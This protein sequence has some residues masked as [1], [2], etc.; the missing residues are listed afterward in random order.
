RSAVA[1]ATP[2]TPVQAA[3]PPPPRLSSPVPPTGP[4]RQGPRSKA[5][6]DPV[7]PATSQHRPVRAGKA[8][9]RCSQHDAASSATARRVTVALRPGAMGAAVP[10]GPALPLAV[11]YWEGDDQHV[12]HRRAVLRPAGPCD[13]APAPLPEGLLRRDGPWQDGERGPFLGPAIQDEV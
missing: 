4:A 6:A 12:Q 5:Y 1:V 11:T 13:P 2:Q 10:K 7:A 3:P 8:A 9:A